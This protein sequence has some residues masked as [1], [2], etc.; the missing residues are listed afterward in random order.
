MPPKL[1]MRLSDESIEALDLPAG[2]TSRVWD[3]QTPGLGLQQTPAGVRSFFFYYR[4]RGLGK[5]VTLGKF[6]RIT[7]TDARQL[8][9]RYGR[10]VRDGLDPAEEKAAERRGQSLADF[11]KEYRADALPRWK[12]STRRTAEWHWEK[13]IRPGLGS[14]RLNGLRTAEIVTW[15]HT[16]RDTKAKAN[17]GLRLLKA[18]LAKAVEW[19]RIPSSP[20]RAVKPYPLPPRETFLQPDEIAILFEAI[21]EEERLGQLPPESP[22][23][24]KTGKK[25]RA[26]QL[27]R[28][29]VKR[30]GKSKGRGGK[31]K[32]ETE[33]RG[34]TPHAAALFRLLI[35]TGARLSEI[36]TARWSWVRWEEKELSLPDAKAGPRRVPLSG[37][38]ISELETLSNYRTAG[39]PFLIEGIRPG[40]R[41]V[42]PQKPWGR[43]KT[44]A[45]DLY[46]EKAE[47][48]ETAETVFDSLRIHDLRHTAASLAAGAGLSLLHIGSALGHRQART[49]ER[50]SHL[51]RDAALQTAESI[52]AIIQK[53]LPKS[54]GK[55]PPEPKQAE[56]VR[57]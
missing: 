7:T 8:V 50:Y 23:K 3:S 24:T 10:M 36:M 37:A 31:G 52:A 54:S 42:N 57:S 55:K 16:M 4:W 48:P 43:I 28:K 5:R 1:R 22:K 56:G 19:D 11:W 47:L 53:A 25:G 38:A 18:I 46:R 9:K 27:L 40:A 6:G 49:T 20:A 26:R 41:L 39:N 29:A 30:K 35:Y 51:R 17:I 2:R 13:S 21:W 14:K 32:K 33:S 44:R 12:P 34:I 45:A 15:R